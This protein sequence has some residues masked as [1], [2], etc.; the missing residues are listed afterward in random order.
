MNIN[1]SKKAILSLEC[2]LSETMKKYIHYRSMRN[3]VLHYDEIE[4]PPARENVNVL[5]S[6]Y[7]EEIK[8]S[9]YDFKGEA[10]YQLAR[11]YLFNLSGYYKEYSNFMVVMRIQVM[12][13]YGIFG[14]SLLYFTK[15]PS[16]I[17]HI[18]IVT[19][20]FFLNYLYVIIFKAPKGRV[21][22]IFY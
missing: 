22:G 20:C 13:L 18:P 16:R 7:I 11:K 2:M 9:N 17:W 5:L 3:F 6:E 8:A 10:S 21:Y 4:S 15:I 14:D 12:L 1:D 19:V